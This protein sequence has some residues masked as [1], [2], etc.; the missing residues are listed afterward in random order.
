MGNRSLTTLTD[1]IIFD[2]RLRP[3]TTQGNYFVK[4]K[5][6]HGKKKKMIR[7]LQPKRDVRVTTITTKSGS[8]T[9]GV[10]TQ[11]GHDFL[12]FQNFYII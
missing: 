3:Q 7:R 2:F 9:V 4:R 12:I 6:I 11:V 5:T 10:A 8:Q 1:R